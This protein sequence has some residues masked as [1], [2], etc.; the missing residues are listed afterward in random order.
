[1]PERYLTE[2]I[3]AETMARYTWPAVYATEDDLPDG[4]V[5]EFPACA[6]YFSEGFEGDVELEF[7]PESTGTG[8]PI[9]LADALLAL[10]PE[11]TRGPEPLTPGLSTDYE[12]SASLKKVRTG[13]DDI[14]RILQA[15]FLPSI[16]GDLSWAVR[17]HGA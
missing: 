2:E 9:T 1:M 15:H 3:V 8:S 16:A 6:I 14:C 13:V 10:I 11:H 5:V 7:L 12:P 4:I 17:L